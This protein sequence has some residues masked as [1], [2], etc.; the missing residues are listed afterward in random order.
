[1]AAVTKVFP[2][3]ATLEGA[4]IAF[5]YNTVALVAGDPV[6]LTGAMPD[7]RWEYRC[8]KAA[9]QADI[10]GVALKAANAGEGCDICLTGEIDGFSGL[11]N[12]ASLTVVGGNLDT[13]ASTEA[14]PQ[15]IATSDTRIWKRF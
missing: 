1:M 10:H 3:L 6:V 5:A 7:T 2:E 4:H 14:H 12:G 9:A 8:T 11:T 15:F 13:T